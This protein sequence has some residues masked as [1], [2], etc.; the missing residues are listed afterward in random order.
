MRSAAQSRASGARC[1]VRRHLDHAQVRRPVRLVARPTLVEHQHCDEIARI[2]RPVQLSMLRLKKETPC[3]HEPSQRLARVQQHGAR[4]DTNQQLA[5]G[6]VARR[7]DAAQLVRQPSVR[8]RHQHKLRY[9]NVVVGRPRQQ[10]RPALVETLVKRPPYQQQRTVQSP[11][12]DG[13]R[14]QQLARNVT[15]VQTTARIGKFVR[16]IHTTVTKQ[17]STKQKTGT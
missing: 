13:E 7:A 8:K 16:P 10:I 1:E 5:A 9:E 11:H 3:A 4:A 12:G 6:D 14:T 15:K 2:A 17:V